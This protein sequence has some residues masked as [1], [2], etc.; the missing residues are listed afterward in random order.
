VIPLASSGASSPLSAASTASLQTA[1]IRTLM[2]TAPRPRRP[3]RGFPARRAT[4]PR[5]PW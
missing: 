1:V 4:L 5:S 2:E 3:G